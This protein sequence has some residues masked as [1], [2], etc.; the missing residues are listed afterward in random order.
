M[1]GKVG[2][3][4]Q[5]L[6]LSMSKNWTTSDSEIPEMREE[7]GGIGRVTDRRDEQVLY[8]CTK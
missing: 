5:V 8:Y 3:S 6:D 1:E 2:Y 7:R 4:E